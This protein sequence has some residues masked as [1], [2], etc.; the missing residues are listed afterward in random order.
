MLKKEKIAAGADMAITQLG[1]D[2]RKFIELK[3]YLDERGLSVPLIG[4]I[5]V[6][7]LRGAKK[8]ATDFNPRFTMKDASFQNVLNF[9]PLNVRGPH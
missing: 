4:G 5:Y 7:D 1:W 3:R 9:I 8:T 6:L 2:V